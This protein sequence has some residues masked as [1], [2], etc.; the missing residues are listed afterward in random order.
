[1]TVVTLNPGSSGTG[2]SLSILH[3]TT[4]E[5]QDTGTA[6]TGTPAEANSVTEIIVTETVERVETVV[7]NCVKCPGGTTQFVV[8]GHSAVTKTIT[9]CPETIEQGN[10]PT[11]T[12][13]GETTNS[14]VVEKTGSTINNDTFGN[15]ATS[16]TVPQTQMSTSEGA[17]AT[18]VA[19]AQLSS[20]GSAE[21]NS[22]TSTTP[23]V[24]FTGGASKH[25]GVTIMGLLLPVLLMV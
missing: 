25:S 5:G 6:P 18:S 14:E 7:T 19:Q 11:G 4:F 10:Q 2:L 3:V 8:T 22:S 15:E 12:S 1:M 16:S 13:G 9:V 23:S 20:G 24:T 21:G 17:A